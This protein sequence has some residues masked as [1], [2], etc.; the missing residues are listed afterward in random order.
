MKKIFFILIAF[1]IFFSC[2]SSKKEI[3][4]ANNDNQIGSIIHP[5]KKLM[6]TNCNICHSP[7]ATHDDRLGPPMV[8]VKRHYIDSE[9]S[10]E[11]FINSIQGWI[12]NP[13]E[14][15]A[16]MF[17]A[18]RRFGVMPK[19]SFPEDTIT[20]IAEYLYDYD[21]EKPEWFDEHHN[22]EKFKG[23]RKRMN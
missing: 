8:A 15:D 1:A 4:I 6:E 10:K 9:T 21:I 12:E 7:T 18:V 19:Q 13:N 16:K 2:N 11:D 22:N 20:L 5:G 23:K 3:Y 17:G 14:D